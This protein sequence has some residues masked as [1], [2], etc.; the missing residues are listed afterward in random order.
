MD[1]E[2]SDEYNLFT[3]TRCVVNKLQTSD[4]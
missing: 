3:H 2:T 4:H 1:K